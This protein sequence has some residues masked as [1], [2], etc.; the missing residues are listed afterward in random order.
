MQS[1]KE[2]EGLKASYIL[3]SLGFARYASVLIIYIA[4]QICFVYCSQIIL[5][6]HVCEHA[7]VGF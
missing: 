1:V 2:F 6:K 4:L 5:T 3:K 7:A